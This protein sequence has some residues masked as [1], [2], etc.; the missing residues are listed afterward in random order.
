MIYNFKG[1]SDGANPE[2]NLVAVKSELYG[3]TAG[4]GTQNLGTVFGVSTLGK[5]VVLHAFKTTAEGSD[6]RARLAVVNGVLYGTTSAGGASQM[7]T[8]FKVAP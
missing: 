7:G 4:G 5:E 3:T 6:P 1:G 2:A 8:I